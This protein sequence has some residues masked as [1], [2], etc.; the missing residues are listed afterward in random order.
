MTDVHYCIWKEE[1]KYFSWKLNLLIWA[2]I[3]PAAEKKIVRQ[4]S[5]LQNGKKWH[6]RPISWE[7]LPSILKVWPWLR[8][9][10][11]PIIKKIFRHTSSGS[12]LCESPEIWTGLNRDTNFLICDANNVVEHYKKD[13]KCCTGVLLRADLIENGHPSPFCQKGWDG[14]EGHPCRIWFFS[15]IFYYIISTE[16]QKIV[17]LFCPVIILDFSTVWKADLRIFLLKTIF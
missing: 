11:K 3:V 13:F 5:V 16:Y 15:I 9:K 1:L 12:T 2:Q 14:R 7:K 4:T 10:E 8:K 17:E 6:L